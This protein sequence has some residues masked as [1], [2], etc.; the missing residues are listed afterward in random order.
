M[1][2]S[3]FI[4]EENKFY[5]E[6]EEGNIEYKWR[7][8]M[9]SDLGIKKLVTQMVWRVNEGYD[10]NKIYEA[11]Y[12]L[13]VYDSGALGKLNEE[14]INST[15]DVFKQIVKLANCLILQEVKKNID[16]SFVY[17]AH[18]IREDIK[19]INERNVLIIGDP[20]SGKTSLISNICY[21]TNV[22]DQ[23]LKHSHEKITGV[24][25]DIK[26][27]I[28]GI[29]SNKIINYTDYWAWDD[30]VSQCDNIVNIYDIPVINNK[31]VVNYILGIMPDHMIII[32]TDNK[33]DDKNNNMYSPD[34]DFYI[35]FCSFYNISFD[36]FIKQDLMSYDKNVF[37]NIFVKLFDIQQ[38]PIYPINKDESIFRINNY[39]DI[40]D[41]GIIVSGIQLNKN[42]NV[43]D[44]CYLVV[45]D[46]I[47]NIKIKSIYK[48][49]ISYTN[50][51]TQES[52]SISFDII[53]KKTK[54]KQLKN[55][56][57]SDINTYDYINA[58]NIIADS[59]IDVGTYNLK[60]FNG[61]MNINTIGTI[62][63][64]EDNITINF[65]NKIRLQDSNIIISYKLNELVLCKIIN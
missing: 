17:Y 64:N 4:Q 16:N 48:K 38:K 33:N 9:K 59:D 63:K 52:G 14:E 47:I 6:N 13:G 61:N 32:S 46:D 56:Y 8:D 42:I 44:T 26:K 20:Q 12:L 31:S 24:T 35:K 15:I 19:V 34:V 37:T 60:I 41:K 11:H 49:N 51:K 28:I 30:I 54:I 45:G 55:A 29:K 1:F 43:G 10:L 57:I 27:E 50:I 62:T 25:T 5:P 7:L 65:D 40:P 53:D 2:N 18:I 22:R 58:I 3:L 23:I 36:V 21:D 39:Y